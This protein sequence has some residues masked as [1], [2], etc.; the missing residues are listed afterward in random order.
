MMNPHVEAALRSASL[1]ADRLM[2]AIL[3]AMF[4][5]ALALSGLHDTL[6][7]A[8]GIGLPAALVPTALMFVAGGSRLTRMAMALALIVMCALHIHQGGGRDELHFGLFVL[9]AF[10]LCYRDWS[11]IVAAAALTAVHHVSFNYLQELG[12]GVRCL[13]EPGFGTVLVHA[14]YVV[15]ETAVLCFLAVQLRREALRSAELR[16]SVTALQA[17]NGAIDLRAQLPVMSDSGRALQDVV[18]LL[19]RSLASVQASVGSTRAASDQIAQGNAELSLRSARQAGAI[20]ATVDSMAELTATVRD[21]AEHARQADALAGSASGVAARGGQVV[22]QVAERMASIDASS[23]RIADIIAVIDG[24]AF[25][26]NILALNAAVEAARAG[27]Q[28]RGFAVV[29]GEVRN[30]AQ[31][32]AGAAREIKALIEES[33]AQVSAGSTLA[34]QAGRTMDEV[35]ESVH[36]VSDIIGQIS[37]ASHAQA[38]GIA[39]IGEAVAAMDGDTRESA[40][41]VHEAAEAAGALKQEAD[42]LARVVAVFHLDDS[43]AARPALRQA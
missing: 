11:V 6:G 35:V 16:A 33:V 39:A 14:A 12:Y 38:Q 5:M 42:R 36:R 2:A 10:L 25:Q 7:W 18:R 43:S 23:R 19:Q 4:G 21:N 17:G 30:L 32:S 3:W 13:A 27:E 28:G 41:M 26:T 15:A 40:A 9:L 22:A 31:R 37:S 1:Q 24:I 29:A 8:L 20:R 34:Q